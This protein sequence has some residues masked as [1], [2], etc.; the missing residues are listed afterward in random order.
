MDG[1]R[2]RWHI[3]FSGQTVTLNLSGVPWTQVTARKKA[4][5]FRICINLALI[6]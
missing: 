2:Q 6:I 4:G 3:L 1:G 5:N